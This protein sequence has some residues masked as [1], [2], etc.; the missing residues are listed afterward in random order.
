MKYFEKE[1]NDC[2]TTWSAFSSIRLIMESYFSKIIAQII[3]DFAILQI[4]KQKKYIT[5]SNTPHKQKAQNLS[6]L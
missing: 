4:L 2:S 6:L 1:L 3:H 5:Q